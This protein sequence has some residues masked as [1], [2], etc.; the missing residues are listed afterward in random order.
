MQNIIS[1]NATILIAAFL[2][3]AVILF[4]KE[5]AE[6]VKNVK[7]DP[8]L[9]LKFDLFV[10]TSEKFLDDVKYVEE[11]WSDQKITPEELK[12]II[13]RI[14]AYKSTIEELL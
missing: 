10:K 3:F 11:A 4:R 13:G 8:K 14:T 2:F 9:L 12:E 6:R 7:L 1:D 5:I